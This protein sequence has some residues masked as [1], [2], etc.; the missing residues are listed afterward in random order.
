ML[1]F[2]TVDVPLPD[3]SLEDLVPK[4]NLNSHHEVTLGL[5]FVRELVWPVYAGGGRSSV[6]SVVARSG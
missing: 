1:G 3:V 2:R 4:G 6:D 5:S